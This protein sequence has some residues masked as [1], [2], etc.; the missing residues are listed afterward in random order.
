MAELTVSRDRTRTILTF[1]SGQRLSDVLKAHGIPLAQP[2]G[3]RG[4]CGKCS[5]SLK[6]H[7]S[8]PGPAEQKAG[9]RLACQA[10]L[11][12]NCEAVL[13]GSRPLEQ[14]ET[15]SEDRLAPDDPFPGQ[16]GA[17]VDIGTT[18]IVLS[19]YDLKTGRCLGKSGLLNPQ[20]A[21]AADVMGRIGAALAGDGER[22]RGQATCAVSVLLR[23]ACVR[24]GIDEARVESLVVT[25][26]TTMLYLLTG[27]SPAALSRAPFRADW[28]FDETVTLCGRQA[29]LPPCMHAFVGADITCAV[30]AGGLCGRRETSLLCDV[31]TNGELALWKE[32]RLLVTSTA[33]GPAFEA[34]GI[35]C[36][37][38]SVAGAIDR[39]WIQ[40]GQA[41]VHTIA[42]APPA[43][44]CGSGLIDAVA[45][46][47]ALHVIDETGA[48]EEEAWP[49]A[50]NVRLLPA[51]I[52]AVQLAKAAIAAG[53]ETL[54]ETAGI[55]A[56]DLEVFYVA[57][58][59]G[60]HLNAQSAAAIGLFPKDA[61]R[62]ARVLGNAA[63]AGA[64]L[65]LMDQGKK[66]RA[67]QIAAAAR[68]VDLGGNPRFNQLY[69]EHML[70]PET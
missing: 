3:G 18:T 45:A 34:A 51:D 25:G 41:A 11:L 15:G 2:C 44:I 43:G 58:G 64:A 22:L 29:Y 61:A 70:F 50:G 16:Y 39:V 21:V 47:L 19:L 66:Q 9:T 55:Q 30:L 32:G 23:Q 42:Q 33:A 62:K 17:A 1:E 46:G 28:L 4:V 54:L 20:S 63:L 26:N 56:R 59:F 38:G 8:P 24:A 35:S 40:E 60:S 68:H 7:I 31:G 69:M 48:L 10:V 57:G 49:L 14:I 12:G 52:R 27:R 37:C 13:P 67:R 65:L 53:L 6:G 36:G 5:V